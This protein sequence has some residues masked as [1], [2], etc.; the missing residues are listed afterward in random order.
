MQETTVYA[1]E[2]VWF[3][4]AVISLG[5]GLL[6][7]AVVVFAAENLKR[8]TRRHALALPGGGICPACGARPLRRLPRRHVF[9]LAALFTRR[10]PYSCRRCTW[11]ARL[12]GPAMKQIQAQYAGRRPL[13]ASAPDFDLH[14]AEL[15]IAESGRIEPLGLNEVSQGELFA[16]DEIAH[17]DLS[18]NEESGTEL[19]GVTDVTQAELVLNEAG[20]IEP[21]A[22]NEASQVGLFAENDVTQAVLLAANEASGGSS[23]GNTIAQAGPAADDLEG[24]EPLAAKYDEATVN[25][26]VL[27][28]LL[29]LKAGDMEARANGQGSGS[30]ALRVDGGFLATEG[31]SAPSGEGARDAGE[32]LDLKCR[33]LRTQVHRDT[34]ISTAYL[35][36]TVAT[37]SGTTRRAVVGRGSWVHVRQDG[38]WKIA[39]MHLSP[40]YS[41]SS[42]SQQSGTERETLVTLL[43]QAA[44]G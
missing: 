30:S 12:P 3:L 8:L 18:L 23:A 17:T 25:A 24:L 43:N 16:A 39:H 42:G 38:I 35:F 2:T 44:F 19:P 4:L 7:G 14:D 15:L 37:A 28:Y 34:A 5:L 29:H 33:D 31:L 26:A 32:I 40:M 36:G 1:W 10:W 22:A 11:R 21:A 13:A 9:R 6:L 27:S 20:A 41:D